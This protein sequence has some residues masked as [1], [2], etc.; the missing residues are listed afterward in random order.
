MPYTPSYVLITSRLLVFAPSAWLGSQLLSVQAPHI[1]V[2]LWL[3]A[4]IHGHG[5]SM[6][7]HNPSDEREAKTGTGRDGEEAAQWKKR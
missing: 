4:C 2:L 7:S 3:P 1:P 5:D 6:G